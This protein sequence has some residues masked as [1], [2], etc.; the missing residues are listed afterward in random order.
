[1]GSLRGKG[2]ASEVFRRCWKATVFWGLELGLSTLDW[3]FPGD[4]EVGHGESRVKGEEGSKQ[5]IMP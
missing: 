1:M 3:E 5:C 2:E 4:L